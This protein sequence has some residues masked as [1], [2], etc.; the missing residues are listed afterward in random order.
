MGIV[1][2][3]LAIH[4]LAATFWAGSTFTLAR[5]GGKSAGALFGPQM[6]AAAASI[7]A[8]GYLWH[9]LF[10]SGGHA[11]LG[12]GAL[13]AVVAAIVQAVLVGRV[14]RRIESDD[15]ARARALLGHRI[16]GGLLAV[17]IVCMVV[18]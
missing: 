3:V 13:A 16:A 18:Q 1:S 12:A 17:A 11:V 4:V 6:G 14:R 9:T 2:V 8:G 10:V 5:I 15:G 7:V